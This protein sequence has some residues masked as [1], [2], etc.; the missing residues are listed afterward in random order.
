MFDNS[1]KLSI[2]NHKF[3][4]SFSI[5]LIISG[6]NVCF[7][8]KIWAH[9]LIFAKGVLSSCQALFIKFFINSKFS[10][11]GLVSFQTIQKIIGKNNKLT[12][13]ANSQNIIMLS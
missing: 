10:S 13:N 4:D 6:S 5:S 12:K 2:I 8:S 11:N 3:L 7:C 9:K 1:S